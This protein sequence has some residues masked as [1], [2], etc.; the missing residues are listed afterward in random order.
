MNGTVGNALC[1]TLVLSESYYSQE[2][3]VQKSFGWHH[4]SFLASLFPQKVHRF[5]T[6]A[7][8]VQYCEK[9]LQNVQIYVKINVNIYLTMEIVQFS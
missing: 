4:R 5:V 8:G 1:G 7:I 9:C 6:H 3:S 2:N